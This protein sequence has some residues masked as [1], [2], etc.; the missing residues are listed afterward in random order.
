MGSRVVLVVL[1][2]SVLLAAPAVALDVPALGSPSAPTGP[3]AGVTAVATSLAMGYGSEGWK[4]ESATLGQLAG[5]SPA[6]VPAPPALP[7]PVGG[8]GVYANPYASPTVRH[9]SPVPVGATNWWGYNLTASIEVTDEAGQP[10]EGEYVLAA[11]IDSPGGPVPAKLRRNGPT[12]F[13]AQFDLDGENGRSDFSAL[14]PGDHAIVVDVA[15]GGSVVANATIP[16]TIAPAFIDRTSFLLPDASLPGMND[17]AAGNATPFLPSLVPLS[18]PFVA[19]ANLGAPN[20]SAEVVAV[21][22]RAATRIATGTTDASGRLPFSFAPSSLL[23]TATSGLVVVEAH[24]V[25]ERATGASAVLALPVSDHATKVSAISLERAGPAAQLATIAIVAS[26][27]DGGARRGQVLLTKG[28]Q[29]LATGDFL[30]TSFAQGTDREARVRADDLAR[31]QGLTSYGVLAMLLTENGGFYSFATASRGLVVSA[32]EMEIGPRD[33]AALRV[34][35][36]SL[37]DNFDADADPGLELTV[38][39][40][41][42]GLPGG[43]TAEQQVTLAEGEEGEF[44]IVI[45]ATSRRLGEYAAAIVATADELAFFDEIAIVVRDEP[46]ALQ[47]LFS[48]VPAPGALPALVAILVVAAVAGRARASRP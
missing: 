6:P 38:D 45:P 47:Q 14:P 39:V 10:V 41:V 18:E 42:T 28:H 43:V 46:S 4:D 35:V 26:D 16:F 33:Q 32:Q 15:Q 21:V 20:A 25:G 27:P 7:L 34:L 30:P 40:R 13:V 2:L 44:E 29:V 22:G 48:R 17:V 8:T 11:R 5:Q 23:G 19:N 31:Y 36:R 37:T 3:A 24:L 12:S 1:A 9:A